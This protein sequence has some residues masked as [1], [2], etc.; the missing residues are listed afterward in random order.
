M[1][2]DR[3]PRDLLLSRH[4]GAEPQLNRLRRAALPAES[5]R[6]GASLLRE[7]FFPHRTAWRAL[8]A[9]W[10]GLAVFHFTLGR[11]RPPA[12]PEISF[13]DLEAWLN[14][15]RNRETFAHPDLHR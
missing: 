12:R 7:L 3:T 1:K 4:A 5:P 2:P 8:A 11:P 10:L 9:V 15:S 13:A 14:Q 6:A